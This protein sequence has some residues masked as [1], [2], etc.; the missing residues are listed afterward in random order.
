MKHINIMKKIVKI[1]ILLGIVLT[2]LGISSCNN[3]LTNSN[4]ESGLKDK[5]RIYIDVSDISY[6]RSVST[7]NPDVQAYKALLTNL[8][9]KGSKT[10][11]GTKTRLAGNDLHDVLKIQE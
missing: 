6:E 9:L 1:T 3:G 2:L 5:C 11:S 4:L 7:I 8:E 10:S